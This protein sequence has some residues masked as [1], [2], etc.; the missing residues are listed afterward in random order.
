VL[1]LLTDLQARLGMSYL[2]I[3]HDL[4]VIRAVAHRIVV[5]KDGAIVERGETASIMSRPQ[6][7]YTQELLAAAFGS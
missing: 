6:H 7:P 4:A 5:M 1:K 2:F 3:S